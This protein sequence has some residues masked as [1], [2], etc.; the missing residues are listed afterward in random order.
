MTVAKITITGQITKN[1][2]KRYTEGN[3]AISAFVMDF[4]FEGQEKLIKVLAM[5]KLADRVTDTVKKGQS[6]LVEGRLQTSTYTE[7]GTE[8]KTNE[9]H[10]QGVEIIEKSDQAYSQGPPDNGMSNEDLIGEDEIPF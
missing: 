8:K 2:E 1:P 4:G 9:I 7:A 5:G 3:L 10:A 6:V